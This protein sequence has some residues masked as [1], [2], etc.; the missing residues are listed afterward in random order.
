M[1]PKELLLNAAQLIE[2]K[3]WAR[4]AFA[5]NAA[6]KECCVDDPAACSF[7]LEGAIARVSLYGRDSTA[8]HTQ[9]SR[10]LSATH[11]DIVVTRVV[12]VPAIN[13][14][15]I[16]NKEQAVALLRAAAEWAGL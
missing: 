7:C 15:H 14:H 3:D 8:A 11:K 2:D 12:Y 13:D 6:G 4:G 16:A 5:R 10:F 9:L 1:T